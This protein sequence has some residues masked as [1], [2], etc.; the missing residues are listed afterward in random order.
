MQGMKTTSAWRVDI[1]APLFPTLTSDLR[2]HVLVVGEGITGVTAAVKLK[3]AGRTVA[4]I[5]RGKIGGGET[6]HTTA[7]ITYVTDMRL[8]KLPRTFGRDHEQA[9]WDAGLPIPVSPSSLQTGRTNET[10]L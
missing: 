3:R 4:M 2:V 8:S 6:G 10:H 5:E 9:A 1:E 7:H